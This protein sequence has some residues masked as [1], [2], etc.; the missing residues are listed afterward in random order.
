M[1]LFE[2]GFG[3]FWD[4]LLGGNNHKQIKGKGWSAWK[5]RGKVTELNLWVK[6][7]PEWSKWEISHAK[8]LSMHNVSL[9]LNQNYFSRGKANLLWWWI[10]HGHLGIHKSTHVSTIS[11]ACIDSHSF[12]QFHHSLPRGLVISF[13]LSGGS[14][15][16]PPPKK[17]SYQVEKDTIPEA[18][19]NSNLHQTNKSYS[20]SARYK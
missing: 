6:D 5:W 16:V 14:C 2:L 3:I 10:L 11:V 13:L 12:G 1:Q 20:V 15:P 4:L 9:A 18:K 7:F 17:K 8:W 19:S